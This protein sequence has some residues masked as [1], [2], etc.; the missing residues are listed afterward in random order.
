M[1]AVQSVPWNPA[2]HGL[3]VYYPDRRRRWRARPA[4]EIARFLLA[5]ATESRMSRFVRT[6]WTGTPG[7]V[8]VGLEQVYGGPGIVITSEGQPITAVVLD[9]ADVVVHTTRPVA[10]PTSSSACAREVRPDA[11]TAALSDNTPTFAMS[12]AGGVVRL[13]FFRHPLQR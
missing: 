12:R 13:Q 1:S 8:Q 11:P 4:E 7:D 3:R 5:V 6:I 10:T 9:V 2:T